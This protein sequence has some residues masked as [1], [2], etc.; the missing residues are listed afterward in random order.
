[1]VIAVFIYGK[2]SCECFGNRMKPVTCFSFHIIIKRLKKKLFGF[3]HNDC[4]LE[5]P[6]CHCQEFLCGYDISIVKGSSQK[7][8]PGLNTGLNTDSVPRL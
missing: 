8:L 6:S 5:D 1:M 4:L 7:I 2:S 3:R